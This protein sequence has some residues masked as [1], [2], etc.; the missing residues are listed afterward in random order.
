VN[1]ADG[2]SEIEGKAAMGSGERFGKE[3][4]SNPWLS[5]LSVRVYSWFKVGEAVHLKE[6]FQTKSSYFFTRIHII[7]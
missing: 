5:A 2:I 3:Q 6:I 1:R 4:V 7:P